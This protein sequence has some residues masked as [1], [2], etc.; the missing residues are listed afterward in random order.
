M[1]NDEKEVRTRLGRWFTDRPVSRCVPSH[2]RY[3]QS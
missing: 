1:T 3:H 2:S